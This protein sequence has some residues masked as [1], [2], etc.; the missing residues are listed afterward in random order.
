MLNLLNNLRKKTNFAHQMN[1]SQF[2]YK[3]DNRNDA[4]KKLAEY[5]KKNSYKDLLDYLFKKFPSHTIP[6]YDYP[7][8]FHLE[9]LRNTNNK[10]YKFN[11]IGGS[12]GMH[13]NAVNNWIPDFVESWKI[14]EAKEIYLYIKKKEIDAS[15]KVKFYENKF[16]YDNCDILLSSGSLQYFNID[17]PINVILGMNEKPK[18]IFFNQLPLDPDIS[19]NIYTLQNIFQNIVINTVFSKSK[20]IDSI[21]SYGYTIVD[22]WTDFSANCNIINNRYYLPYYTG[23]FYKLK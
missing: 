19:D 17:L 9:K 13:F 21:E 12:F 3:F 22:E 14:Y 16:K 1:H 10:K 11:D 8:L 6:H 7:I 18:Y 15:D 23:Q 20:F 4:K 2:C 5:E